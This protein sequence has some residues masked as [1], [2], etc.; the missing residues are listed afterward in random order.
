VVEI[1]RDMVARLQAE[2]PA[3]AGLTIHQAD[4]LLSIFRRL[5]PDLRV[6]GNL[7]YNIS[8]PAAVPSGRPCGAHPS[9]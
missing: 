3:A 6:V 4:A 9:T 1:D 7:P 5:G 8:S 2:F